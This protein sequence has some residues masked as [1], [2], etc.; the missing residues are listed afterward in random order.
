M[1]DLPVCR[2]GITSDLNCEIGAETPN[3]KDEPRRERAR[4]VLES[5]SRSADSFRTRIV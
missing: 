4:L 1:H 3:V 5:V 2:F